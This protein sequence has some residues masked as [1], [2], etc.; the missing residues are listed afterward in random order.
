MKNLLESLHRL[1]LN[2]GRPSVSEI[3]EKSGKPTDGDG[4]LGR[5]T[6]SYVMSTPRLPNFRKM[7]RL[8]AVLVEF[9]PTGSMDLDLTITEFSN[10]WKAAARAEDSPP[11]S[12]R[13]QELRQTANAYLRLADQYQRAE[14]MGGRV[15]SQRTIA[16]EW[17]YVAE[18]SAPLLG[19]DHPVTVEAR[20]RAGNT[21]S[22]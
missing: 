4:Y 20:E 8:V 3:S 22:G 18:L 9:E 11:P 10:L 5:S 21:D 6:I 15:I 17:A 2:V 13:V 19:D 16:D 1:H 7:Q 12:R 14:H